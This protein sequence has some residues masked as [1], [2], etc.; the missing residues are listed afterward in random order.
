MWTEQHRIKPGFH[1]P[2]YKL[3]GAGVGAKMADRRKTR[4][5]I[6]P[7][8]TGGSSP[9][10]VECH[11]KRML[12]R[13]VQGERDRVRSLLKNKRG[14][15]QAC[16]LCPFRT[17]P[18]PQ[19]YM[20]HLEKY[21]TDQN[22]YSAM[23]KECKSQWNVC[24][25]LYDQESALAVVSEP[26]AR[27]MYLQKSAE[28]IRSW[29][30]P[31]GA[32]LKLLQRLNSLKL[33]LLLTETGP[34][35][36]L[37]VHTRGY[38]ML[39]PKVYYTRP[40]ASIVFGLSLKHDGKLLPMFQDLI[41][42][43]VR[44]GCPCA[45]LFLGNVEAR[46]ELVQQIYKTEQVKSLRAAALREASERG[47]WYLLNHD[48]SYKSLA[49]LIGQV[50]MSQAAGEKHAVHTFVGVTGCVAGISLQRS[51][52]IHCLK[53]AACE[54]LPRDMRTNVRWLG[55][56]TPMSVG[57]LR[58]LKATFPSLEGVI[59]DAIH[60]VFRAE[61]CNG[62][63]R[64][65]MSA[66]LMN[67]QSKF[68][69]PKAG[70]V[71]EGVGSVSG[72]IG[73]WVSQPIDKKFLERDWDLYRDSPYTSHQ[74]Y[75]NDLIQL[76]MHFSGEMNNRNKKGD[77]LYSI[78]KNG[79]TYKHYGYLLNCSVFM[80]TV[81]A[82]VRR[83]TPWVT[84]G[85]EALHFQINRSQRAVTGQH[86]DSAGVKF[87]ALA[88]SHLLAHNS[89]AYHSTTTQWSMSDIVSF[90]V[91]RVS[92]EFFLTSEADQ[93]VLMSRAEMKMGGKGESKK[94]V[95]SERRQRRFRRKRASRRQCVLDAAKRL[96]TGRSR[97]QR[98]PK[99][100]ETRHRTVFSK[101]KAR[102]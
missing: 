36:V 35:Y 13:E 6:P 41:A 100:C 84:T 75:I 34:T 71:Y 15:S 61:G 22:C 37:R 17:F 12:C 82:D 72:P 31:D 26:P 32:T 3:K 66:C 21:H 30:N 40:L 91:G 54:V 89:A 83:L 101:I 96:K 56:D 47:A 65:R 93:A 73:T 77:T 48:A 79:A 97:A 33:T 19:R 90:I 94:R 80:S 7:Q 85:N 46:T 60:L 57:G 14:G 64:N 88:L 1:N 29:I 86:L 4:Q 18:R 99:L 39:S 27:P 63:I 58:N 55:T 92:R 67:I 9:E 10:F 53:K 8:I 69:C 5:P 16:L 2:V 49:S 50:Y 70:C 25:A 102:R 68:R 42:M 95:Q 20:A 43:F 74:H 24:K 59:E 38:F 52:G 76:T 62:R 44:G 78:L 28:L 45:S 98:M 23:F 87:E 81:S 51:E 11:V